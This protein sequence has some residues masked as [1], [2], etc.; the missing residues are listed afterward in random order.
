[1]QAQETPQAI[2]QLQ[3]FEDFV[4]STM[5][6]WKVPGLG[7][8]IVKDGEVVFSQ[9]FGKRDV[10]HNVEV[11]PH[12]IFPIGSST[13]AFTTLAMA[14]LADQGK[15]D[16]DRPVKEYLPTFKLYDSFATERLTPPYL[17]GHHYRL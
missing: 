1:M 15:L 3:G 10:E 13:K 8:A 2:P 6:D 12:T 14:V 7:I 16:W 11:T 9:G 5:D 4:Q 17:A